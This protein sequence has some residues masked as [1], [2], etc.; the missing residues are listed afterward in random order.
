MVV[1]P[2]VGVP[3]EGSGSG[4]E[5]FEGLSGVLDRAAAGL[6]AGWTRG[7][8]L[9]QMALEVQK[10]HLR[11]LY[12][13]FQGGL[14]ASLRSLQAEPAPQETGLEPSSAVRCVPGEGGD[15]R[16]SSSS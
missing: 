7:W 12:V 10:P 1:S 13:R 16:A 8:R 5:A 6:G 11:Y 4:K 9:R 14:P 15:R 2:V 3:G